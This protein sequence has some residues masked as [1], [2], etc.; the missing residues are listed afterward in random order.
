MCVLLRAGATLRRG[1][2]QAALH[3]AWDLPEQGR[4]NVRAETCAAWSLTLLPGREIW[5]ALFRR[6]RRQSSLKYGQ[7]LHTEARAF[8]KKSYMYK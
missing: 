5:N 8:R 6:R 7:G 3:M 1:T 4:I 2:Q